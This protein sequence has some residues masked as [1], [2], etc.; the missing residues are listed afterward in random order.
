MPLG[1]RATSSSHNGFTPLIIHTAIH[2]TRY[3]LYSTES[4]PDLINTSLGNS[5]ATVETF[6]Y[7]QHLLIRGIPWAAPCRRH[8]IVETTNHVINSKLLRGT[9]RYKF[10]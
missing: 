5:R 10:Y 8:G 3:L 1:N 4:Q 6:R 2:Y 7:E 9:A